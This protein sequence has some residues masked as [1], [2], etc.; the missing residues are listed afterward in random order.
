MYRVIFI[1]AFSI[2]SFFAF[3]ASAV[4][5]SVNGKMKDECAYLH[6]VIEDHVQVMQEKDDRNGQIGILNVAKS[7]GR[8][9]A[10]YKE[11]CD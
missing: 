8:V 9:V 4:E 3:S 10:I 5:T 7:L 6:Q 11:L 2:L 1:T